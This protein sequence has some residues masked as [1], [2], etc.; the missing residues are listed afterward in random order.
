[1]FLPTTTLSILRTCQQCGHPRDCP[2]TLSELGRVG[3]SSLGLKH[4]RKALPQCQHRSHLVSSK[5]T[6]CDTFL[7]RPSLTAYS[8]CNSPLPFPTVFFSL[9]FVILCHTLFF[10]NVFVHCLRP[11]QECKLHTGREFGACF[12]HYRVPVP[13]IKER[14]QETSLNS[15]IFPQRP[16]VL[17]VPQTGLIY[18][19]KLHFILYLICIFQT[20]LES[21]EL[22]IIIIV[23]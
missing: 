12:V 17:L 21:T 14:I 6:E 7:V 3:S 2:R 23:L 22:M 18:V 5:V 4:P 13:R 15:A 16:C 8:V 20:H 11:P 19:L 10:T 9:A 1:M